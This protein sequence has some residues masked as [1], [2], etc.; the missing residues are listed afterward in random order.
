MTLK[1]SYRIDSDK[2][3]WRNIEGEAVI[4]NLDSGYYYRL[5]PTG[6]RIWQMLAEKNNPE[7]I[8][9]TLATEYSLPEERVERDLEE[10]V[11]DF[12]KEGFLL[13]G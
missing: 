1:K 7:Q 3:A 6:S 10:L 9:K 11:K 13:K 2:L 5:N 12:I 4:L 8:I